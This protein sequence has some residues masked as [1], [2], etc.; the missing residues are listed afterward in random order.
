M[1]RDVSFTQT[2]RLYAHGRVVAW[3]LNEN[4]DRVLLVN[5]SHEQAQIEVPL[6]S[7]NNMVKIQGI[8]EV[9]AAMPMQFWE[10]LGG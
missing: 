8:G 4:R 5:W 3:D 7:C 10:W 2:T 6:I 9:E 1:K